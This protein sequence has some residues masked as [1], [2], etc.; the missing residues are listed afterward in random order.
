MSDTLVPVQFD[1]HSHLAL[2]VK[3]YARR[4]NM[5]EADV[6]RQVMVDSI[7]RFNAFAREGFGADGC[8]IEV[9]GVVDIHA[10]EMARQARGDA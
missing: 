3:E 4:L 9:V 10:T 6:W 8:V 7:E 2:R 1:I 5:P